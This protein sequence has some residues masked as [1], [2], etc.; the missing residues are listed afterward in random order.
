MPGFRRKPNRLPQPWY[1]GQRFYFLTLCTRQGKKVF[2]DGTLVHALLDLL[3]EKCLAHCF[4]LY[5][6]CFMPDHSHLILV[7]GDNSAQLPVVIRAIKGAAAS[8]AR[9]L[10][11]PNLWQKG[12]YDH[13]IR[14]GEGVDRV[15]W[16]I[17]MNP[18]RAGLVEHF[19]EWPFSGSLVFDWKKLAAPPKPFVPPWKK[20]LAG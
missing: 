16:Y 8:W 11:A 10:G 9:A 3:R 14:A 19:N 5:E 12:F 6:Y 13:V 17:L 2:T 15:A 18:V 1:R 20:P 4:G 7:G